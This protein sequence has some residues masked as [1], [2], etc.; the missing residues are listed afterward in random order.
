M[1]LAV[2]APSLTDVYDISHGI[3]GGNGRIRQLRSSVAFSC[4][5]PVLFGAAG[6]AAH[7]P[8]MFFCTKSRMFFRQYQCCSTPSSQIYMCTVSFGNFYPKNAGLITSAC[9]GAFDA[10]SV[11]FVILATVM[12]YFSFDEVFWGYGCVPAILCV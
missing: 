11:I 2:T 7:R 3:I 6:R 12:T 5:N 4:K 9:V 1:T 10:S 8:K